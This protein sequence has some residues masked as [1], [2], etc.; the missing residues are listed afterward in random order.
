MKTPPITVTSK[1]AGMGEALAFTEDL[2]VETA[3]DKKSVLHLRLLA[4]ELFGMLRGIAGDVNADYWLEKEGGKFEL[5]LKSSVKMTDDMREQFLSAASDGKN[6][7]A[8]GFMGKIR[9]IFADMLYYTKEALPYAMMNSAV[10][11]PMGGASV[12][13]STVW[14]MRLYK[15]EL[16]REKADKKEAAENWDELE[17]SIVANIADDVKVKL[18]GSTAEIIIYK[19][20]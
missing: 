12:E 7:A 11:Y 5:H 8:K 20:F 18:I 10:A 17:K 3:L 2:G 13:S 19:T 15:E 4:E 1:G 6:Y 14:S 16:Q 9:V